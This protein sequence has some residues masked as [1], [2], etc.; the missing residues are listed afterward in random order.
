METSDYDE[1]WRRIVESPLAGAYIQE[2]HSLAAEVVQLS[3]EVFQ[4]VPRPKPSDDYVRVDH[5][6]M[7]KLYTIIGDATR[8]SA[9]LNK[10]PRGQQTAR[11][12][13]VHNRRAAWLRNEV[14]EDIKLERVFEA[15]VRHT[16]EHFD[17]YIDRTAIKYATREMSTPSVAPMDFVLGRRK[18]LA[19]ELQGRVPNIY[20]M[21]V[22]IAEERVF[23]NCGYEIDVESLREECREVAKRLT[24]LVPEPL[25]SG[26]RGS[27]LFVITPATFEG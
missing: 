4:A 24:P 5:T 21:R 1:L 23:V 11:Q 25:P 26:E 6:I 8:V 12:H 22:F 14:L 27:P 17:E 10:R 19:I 15:K 7:R 13:E 16:L 3:D 9:M 20:F 18:A 2:L